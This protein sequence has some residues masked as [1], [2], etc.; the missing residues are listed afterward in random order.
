MPSPSAGQPSVRQIL[1]FLHESPRLLL[2]RGIGRDNIVAARG[3]P[4]HSPAADA[5][6]PA[7]D[8]GDKSRVA[9]WSPLG[10][11][12]GHA[13]SWLQEAEPVLD[14]PSEG[15]LRAVEGVELVQ[16]DSVGS[17]GWADVEGILR[18]RAAHFG[19]DRP[20]PRLSDVS[21]RSSARSRGRQNSWAVRNG[22]AFANMAAVE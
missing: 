2:R 14:M 10:K 12:T 15:D 16:A 20:L 3:K 9:H 1:V 21:G 22:H 11:L 19:A 13:P 5:A 17:A 4:E 18:V 6:R 8:K 7:G